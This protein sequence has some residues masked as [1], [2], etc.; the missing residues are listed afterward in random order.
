M[1][2]YAGTINLNLILT[3]KN[4]GMRKGLRIQLNCLKVMKCNYLNLG[5]KW[6]LIRAKRTFTQMQF[7]SGFHEFKVG[8]D[9]IAE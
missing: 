9:V 7:V 1:V 4:C 5:G 2:I 6:H 3:N 8:I